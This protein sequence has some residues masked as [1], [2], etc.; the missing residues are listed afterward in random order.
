[1]NM[2]HGPSEKF[3]W[4]ASDILQALH[5]SFISG[6]PH[7]P[8]TGIS[9]DSRTIA[10][11]N[12]FIAIA[13]ER[14]DGHKFAAECIGKGAAGI[15]FNVTRS[16]ELPI[17]AWEASGICCFGVDNTVEA[18]GL[19][20]RY[21][22]IR[23]GISVTAITGSNGKTTT[24]KMTTAVV[25]RSFE[26]LSPQKNFNNEIGV[27]LTLLEI[28]DHHQWAVL[29]LGTN[30]PGEIGRLTDLCL[31]D[32][33]VVTNVGPAH[34]EG[35]GTLDGVMKEKGELIRRLH[36][37]SS[38]ILNADDPRVSALAKNT[39]ANVVFYGVSALADIRATDIE[40]T[41]S[42]IR[43]LL[44]LPQQS[45][46]IELHTPGYFM[47]SNALAAAA[48]GYCL[49]IPAEHIRDALEKDFKPA[50]GR[51]NMIHLA[52]GIHVIDD[53]Y[54]ANPGSMEA[55][56]RAFKSLRKGSRGILVAGD[57]LEL[58]EYAPGLHHGI[59]ALAAD[60]DVCR[61]YATGAFCRHIA[62]GAQS[63]G[64]D[65]RNVV[66]GP[67]EDLFSDLRTYL[68]PGDWVLVKGSRAMAMEKIVDRLKHEMS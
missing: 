49:N 58:G 15:V 2:V 18:L 68:Q 5:C 12:L 11:G 16:G 6:D 65:E 67:L 63:H 4:E 54:N 50:P 19:L 23:S 17:R 48:V 33:G 47:V 38:A 56:L 10:N 8:F 27:P 42:G 14:H 45:I 44:R 59:G 37:G 34:L 53:T 9:I 28:Q 20:G 52:D 24:R 25:S 55:A 35:L 31:P 64:M 29:E 40:L 61:I 51:M 39:R 60:L 32:I 30:H 13:G 22:R 7:R 41:A 3:A 62:E 46:T 21:H 66:T 57:M 26:A 1:M 36:P 43:F